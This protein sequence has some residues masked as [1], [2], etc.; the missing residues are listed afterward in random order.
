MIGILLHRSEEALHAVDQL[1]YIHRIKEEGI[2]SGPDHPQPNIEIVGMG[3]KNGTEALAVLIAPGVQGFDQQRLLIEHLAGENQNLL[4]PAVQIPEED[5]QAG[6]ALDLI[7]EIAELQPEGVRQQA[8]VFQN[9][10]NPSFTRGR[11]VEW[12]DGFRVSRIF[13]IRFDFVPLTF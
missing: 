3:K 10:E 1:G 13:R 4:L 5:L 8:V 6:E 2:P 9:I 12:P 7:A 11:G